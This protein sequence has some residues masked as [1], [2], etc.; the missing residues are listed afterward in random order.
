MKRI[1]RGKGQRGLHKVL[2]CG[3]KNYNVWKRKLDLKKITYI[4]YMYI[5]NLV[6]QHSENLF[7]KSKFIP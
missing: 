6:A 4:H 1:F 5:Y 7:I 3:W 2:S